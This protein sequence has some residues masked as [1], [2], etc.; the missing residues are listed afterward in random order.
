MILVGGDP[1]VRIGTKMQSPSSTQW[2]YTRGGLDYKARRKKM[3]HPN[4]KRPMV[5][6]KAPRGNKRKVVM[7]KGGKR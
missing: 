1:I 3:V 4:T 7:R 6:K 5:G 2:V